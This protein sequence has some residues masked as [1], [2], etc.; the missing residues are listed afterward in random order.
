[1]SVTHSQL[2]WEVV[3]W[4]ARDTDGAIEGGGFQIVDA[5]GYLISACT[6]EGADEGEEANLGLIVKAVNAHSALLSACKE[7]LKREEDAGESAGS[8]AFIGLLRTALAAAGEP[9]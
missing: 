8:S 7:A 1:M 5:E 6:T 4:T 3:E 9:V 2:P